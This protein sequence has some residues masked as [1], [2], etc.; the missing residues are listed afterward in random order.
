MIRKLGT[1]V[2]PHFAELSVQIYEYLT[3]LVVV[4]EHH[5]AYAESRDGLHIE[6]TRKN[7][8]DLVQRLWSECPPLGG[9]RLSKSGYMGCGQNILTS[10]EVVD[11]LDPRGVVTPRVVK[12][13]REVLVV[14]ELMHDQ[15]P[16]TAVPT[17]KP[18][19]VLP[20]ASPVNSIISIACSRW[21]GGITK[22][23]SNFASEVR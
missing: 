6:R 22:R 13:H 17:L 2:D 20:F 12:K 21:A 5:V 9:E 15:A 1:A 8:L 18:K 16:L 3:T 23:S 19:P 14:G 10:Q 4:A 11:G 7:L